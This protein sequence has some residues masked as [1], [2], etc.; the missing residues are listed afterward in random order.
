[1]RIIA[2]TYGGHFIACPRGHLTHPMSEKMRGAIFNSLGDIV[3][4]SLLDCY[5]GSGALAFEAI[6]RGAGPVTVI[7]KSVNAVQTIKTNL[8]NLGLE[9]DIKIISASIE[10]WLKTNTTFYNLI[11]AD[12]PYDQINIKT[13]NNLSN[14]LMPK[15][16]L[17]LSWP[18]IPLPNI[19]KLLLVKE[20]SFG[21]GQLAFYRLS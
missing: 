20:K 21:D 17:V 9:N 10:S 8:K 18:K 3:D 2:G 4:L 5:S 1:M 13:I 7:D 19:S 16:M 6:S 11:I 12:P 15:G 14:I